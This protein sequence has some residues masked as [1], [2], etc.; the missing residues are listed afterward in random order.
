MRAQILS[1]IAKDMR[2]SA[3]EIA[4]RREQTLPKSVSTP[5][6][7]LLLE[8]RTDAQ[9]NKV[10]YFPFMSI[11]DVHLGTRHSRARRLSHMLEH[12]VTD[13]LKAIGDIVD[14]EYMR[15]KPEWNFAPWH[16]QVLGHLFRK[17]AQL[18]AGNHDEDL[19]GTKVVRD[20][21]HMPRRQWI[22]KEIYGVSIANEAHYT[23][24][25]GRVIKIKHGIILAIFCMRL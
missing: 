16:R 4:Y 1:S 15:R 20:A 19:R 24:P 25:K 9:G 13:D 12:T 6:P 14:L 21:K 18:F 5:M 10:L 22:G 3:S 23:D 7:E 11:S 8:T 17:E 2:S